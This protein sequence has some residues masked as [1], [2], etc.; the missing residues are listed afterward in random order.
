[1]S[2]S[3]R[4]VAVSAIVLTVHYHWQDKKFYSISL[5]SWTLIRQCLLLFQSLLSLLPMNASKFKKW[6]K[7]KIWSVWLDFSSKAFFFKV[8]KIL[9]Q[10]A[11]SYIRLLRWWRCCV[12]LKEALHS[13]DKSNCLLKKITSPKRTGRTSRSSPPPPSH[14]PPPFPKLI[15]KSG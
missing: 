3:Y 13:F 14:P 8:E 5:L 4:C 10:K 6:D 7:V 11:G 15:Y 12:F 9:F 2:C 1:M